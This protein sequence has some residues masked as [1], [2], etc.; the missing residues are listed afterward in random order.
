MALCVNPCHAEFILENVKMYKHFI[1]FLKIEMMQL[2]KIIPGR[3]QGRHLYI[4]IQCGAFIMQWVLSKIFM[5]YI[6]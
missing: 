3:W 5:K 1:W 2:V 4:D 6:P